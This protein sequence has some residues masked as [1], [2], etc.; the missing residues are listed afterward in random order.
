ME[1]ERTVESYLIDQVKKRGGLTYKW[2]APGIRGVPDRIVLVYGQC[3]FFELKQAHGNLRRNQEYQIN[4][5]RKQGQEVYVCYNKSEV[6][7]ALD[8]VL[9]GVQTDLRL[10]EWW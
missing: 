1:L 8:E 2:V 6:D 7:T 9:D 3:V 10:D 5:I 4:K